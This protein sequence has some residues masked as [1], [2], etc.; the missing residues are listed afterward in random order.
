MLLEHI[1]IYTHIQNF[2]L[3]NSDLWPCMISCI[4]CSWTRHHSKKSHMPKNE[5]HISKSWKW[6]VLNIICH[7]DID[8]LTSSS[9]TVCFMFSNEWCTR[10]VHQYSKWIF[11]SLFLKFCFST[12]MEWFA[13]DFQKRRLNFS[14]YLIKQKVQNRKRNRDDKRIWCCERDL[15]NGMA[16]NLIFLSV[17][18]FTLYNIQWFWNTSLSVLC[19]YIQW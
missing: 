11:C 12:R 2:S 10:I 18:L 5:N 3:Y 8:N 19:R 14:I 6:F 17:L 4:K 1:Y 16:H 9:L 7:A 13:T 15:Q